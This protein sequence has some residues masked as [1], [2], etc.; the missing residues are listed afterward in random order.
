M[1]D[2]RITNP[3]PLYILLNAILLCIAFFLVI[4]FF[5]FTTSAPLTKYWQPYL[6]IYTPIS[7]IFGIAFRKYHSYRRRELND[8]LLSILK[9]DLVATVVTCVVFITM[10]SLKL[11]TNALFLFVGVLLLVEYIVVMVYFWVKNA[12]NVEHRIQHEITDHKVRMH[13]DYKLDKQN[14]EKVESLIN[15]NSGKKTLE[16]L[17]EKTKLNYANTLVLST[18]TIFNIS[19]LPD[20]RFSTIIN[21]AR[22]NDIRSI[23]EFFIAVLD[24]LPYDGTFVG[25]YLSKSQY[26]KNFLKKYPWGINYILYTFVYLIKRVFPK[27]G[28][29]REMYFWFTSGR[30]RVLAKPEIY[31]RLYAC[32]FEITNEFRADKLDYF[33]AK[34][35]NNPIR[36]EII[37]YGPIIKLNRVGKNGKMFRVYKFRTMHAYSEFL[38]PYIYERNNL[39]EGGKFKRDIRITSVGHFMRKY[40]LDELPML[41]NLIKGNMKLVGVRPLSRQYFSL[42]SKELQQTRT[43]HKPGLL[44]PFYA[45]M[46]K[47]LD[48]IQAS[49]MKYLTRCEKKGTFITDFKYLGKIF[50]NIVFKQARS[51]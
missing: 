51:T 3:K 36:T 15:K 26:K 13:R 19:N 6:F 37:N 48:E 32:G 18:T 38:Q 4:W 45:D 42:Y 11:S 7:F 43:R 17:I 9:A 23:N 2:Y 10:P 22:S 41:Y 21:L 28:F 8:V 14:T 30:H 49:E 25:C 24:K 5:K 16:K 1:E 12:V 47:T 44:P 39:Q 33:I 20:R 35:R 31:G 27:L 34:K 46:P 29:T 40:W 50:V